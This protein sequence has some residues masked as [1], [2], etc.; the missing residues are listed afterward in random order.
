MN[1]EIAL[2]FTDPKHV[3]LQYHG[4]LTQSYAFKYPFQKQTLSDISWYLEVYAYK[5]TADV[6]DQRARDIEEQL[7]Q[8]GNVLFNATLGQF[9]T[10]PGF[11]QFFGKKVSERRVLKIEASHPEI[12]CLPWELLHIPEGRFLFDSS[13]SIS[14][15]RQFSTRS[16]IKQTTYIPKKKARLLFVVSRP[17]N[18]GFIDPRSDAQAV[19]NSL[20]QD[21]QCRI[22]IEFL[23][24]ATLES[25]R[26]R[27]DA[28]YLPKIDILHFDGHGVY[29]SD[30]RWF[31]EANQGALFGDS[32]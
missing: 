20:E 11:V 30:G 17:N 32:R 29:D 26:N 7:P 19:L 1:K 18:S 8:W 28:H 4:E 31:S 25:L 13:P 21:S 3:A 15:R 22:E 2:V 5:Y 27:L 9:K 24:P 23:R 16:G 10:H 6:D 12:L 14:I